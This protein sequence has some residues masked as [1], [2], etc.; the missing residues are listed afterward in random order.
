MQSGDLAEAR[1]TVADNPLLLG[2]DV[3]D[4]L[5]EAIKRTRQL[6]D[7]EFAEK[8][9]FW[10]ELLRTFRE[11]GVQDGY[12]ELAIEQLVRAP[13]GEAERAALQQYPELAS[14][15]AAEFIQR[16]HRESVELADTS[17]E[18]KY[19]LAS[20]LISSRRESDPETSP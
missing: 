8:C 17:A 18:G 13:S 11:F 4:Y 16:R 1:D 15:A 14:E 20:I 5:S 19:Q 9:E 2:P 7:A 12:L 6:G 3:A 10:L